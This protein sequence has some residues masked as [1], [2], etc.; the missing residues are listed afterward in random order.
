MPRDIGA[1]P[2]MGSDSLAQREAEKV[3]LGIVA[4]ELG[5]S[6][7]ETQKR[8]PIGPA[9]AIV[10]AF[11]ESTDEVV[12]LEVNAR[13][14]S[15][16]KTATKNKVLKDTLKM[17]LIEQAH[18]AEWQGK[19]VRK[20]LV[21]LDPIA[22]ASFGPKAWANQAWD[23][24]GVETHVCAIPDAH[25]VALIAAQAAQDLRADG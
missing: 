11:A 2:R 14:G 16:M 13:V 10:D 8:F 24:F 23:A 17:L 3:A 7:V 9:A 22:R 15:A 20:M 5:L 1:V 25:R 19:R 4:A 18:A 6:H 12:L 21:F